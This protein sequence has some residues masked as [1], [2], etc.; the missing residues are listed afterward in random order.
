MADR[1]RLRYLTGAL[2][3]GGVALVVAALAVVLRPAP[4][5]AAA[6]VTATVTGCELASYGAAQVTFSVTNGDRTVHGY[7]IDLTVLSGTTPVG[8]GTSLIDGVDPGTTASGQA[9]V[10]LTGGATQATCLVRANVH[11]G[12]SGHDRSRR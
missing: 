8:A 1:R 12:H 10:P 7:R 2:A 5:P 3:V 9:L 6:P 4:A 11:D